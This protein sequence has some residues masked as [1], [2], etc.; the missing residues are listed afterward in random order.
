MIFAA[1]DGKYGYHTVGSPGVSKNALTVGATDVNH[2][3]L[4]YFSSIGG[5]NKHHIYEVSVCLY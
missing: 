4:V 3:E 1:N 2:K 5:S